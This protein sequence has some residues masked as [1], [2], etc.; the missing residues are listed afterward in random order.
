[1]PTQLNRTSLRTLSGP[2]LLLWS[3]AVFF[4]LATP[5]FAGE[6]L[7]VAAPQFSL[8]SLDGQ[9][10]ALNDYRGKYLLVNFWATWCGPC[11]VEMPS[12]ES[13]YRKFKKRNLTVVAVSND[14]FGAQ[15]VEPYIQAQNLT[16]PIGLDPKLKVSNQFGVISLPTTFLI[17]PQGKIIGVLNGAE[18]WTDPKTLL[19]FDQLLVTSEK[20][21]GVPQSSSCKKNQKAPC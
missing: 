14:I 16:F 1:M 9:E 3:W 17:N 13:L 7:P 8:P 2:K 20:A 18:N 5:T 12:L 21:A 15:V 19:Y 10:L 11:K 6:D 4:I